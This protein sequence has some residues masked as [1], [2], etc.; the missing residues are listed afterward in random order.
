MSCDLDLNK[1][2]SDTLKQTVCAMVGAAYPNQT[3]VDYVCTEVGL[4]DPE[5]QEYCLVECVSSALFKYNPPV[6]YTKIDA[7]FPTFSSSTCSGGDQSK[8]SRNC[9]GNCQQWKKEQT[10]KENDMFNSCNNHLLD[11]LSDVFGNMSLICAS[12]ALGILYIA[13][14][15]SEITWAD[16]TKRVGAAIDWIAKIWKNIRD[17]INGGVNWTYTQLESDS[18]I[19]ASQDAMTILQGFITDVVKNAGQYIE[20]VA[21]LLYDCA[22]KKYDMKEIAFHLRSLKENLTSL[23]YVIE[24]TFTRQVEALISDSASKAST[25]FNFGAQIE[26]TTEMEAAVKAL[27]ENIEQ[28]QSNIQPYVG[29]VPIPT[30][31]ALEKGSIS[32]GIGAGSTGVSLA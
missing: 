26:Y 25:A 2:R 20:Q 28:G 24:N 1:E 31:Q 30:T 15:L 4:P 7:C 14:H 23:Y 17:L 9:S 16:I 8:Q 18:F 29:D 22:D 11:Y 32:L 13:E 19:K 21:D 27:G 6:V 12:Y 10:C 5:D 3:I